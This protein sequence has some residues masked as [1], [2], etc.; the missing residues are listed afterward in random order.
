MIDWVKLSEL[1]C[2]SSLTLIVSF[3]LLLINRE[4]AK[5][6]EKTR[7]EYLID[8]AGLRGEGNW[9]RNRGEARPLQGEGLRD[10]LWLVDKLENALLRKAELVSRVDRLRLEWL[11]RVGI[12]HYPPQYSHAQA[13]RLWALSGIIERADVL[14][15]KYRF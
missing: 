5:R 9:L 8:V 4:L 15:G 3:L 14:L 10:W 2:A 7:E 6:R 1:V 13:K 11:D 12:L